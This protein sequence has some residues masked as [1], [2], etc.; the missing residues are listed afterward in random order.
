MRSINKIPEMQ[1]FKNFYI[2]NLVEWYDNRKLI[3]G[4]L[5]KVGGEPMDNYRFYWSSDERTPGSAWGLVSSGG[6]RDWN[7]KDNNY[8]NNNRCRAFVRP[9]SL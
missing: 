9:L 5:I 2:I 3:N 4:A 1:S 8:Y 6:G 7:Y